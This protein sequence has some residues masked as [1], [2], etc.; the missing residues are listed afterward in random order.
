MKIGRIQVG[1]EVHLGVV[2]QIEGEPHCLDLTKALFRLGRKQDPAFASMASFIAGGQSALDKAAEVADQAGRVADPEVLVA[3][4]DTTWLVP[5]EEPRN[6]LC[7][8]RNFSSHH[9]ESAE[10][11]QKEGVKIERSKFPT[12][13]AKLPGTLASE[14]ERVPRPAADRTRTPQA[15]GK[16]AG[17]PAWLRGGP[18]HQSC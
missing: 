9:R 18:R 12:G 4:E 3:M 13:F 2:A 5:V 15:A 7:A 11:W 6:F 1:D 14:G 8:G 16:T 10:G 17:W